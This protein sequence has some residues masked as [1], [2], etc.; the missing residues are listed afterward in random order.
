MCEVAIVEEFQLFLNIATPAARQL[1]LLNLTTQ[2]KFGIS[3]FSS[4]FTQVSDKI[5][6]F[7][8]FVTASFHFN[9]VTFT[10]VH[11]CIILNY[12]QEKIINYTQKLF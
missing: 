2:S 11:A 3:T 1:G 8:R 9:S 12:V 10:N 6:I 4:L 7:E 5:N